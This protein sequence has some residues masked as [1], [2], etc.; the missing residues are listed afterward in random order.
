MSDLHQ[1][2]GRLLPRRE[3]VLAGVSGGVD[4][5]VLM[6]L[7][8]QRG[9]VQV[10]HLNHGLRG[11]SSDA[12]ERLVRKMAEKWGLPCHVKRADVK[13]AAR[14][15]QV[16]I[17]MAAR[18]CRHEF[19]ARLARKLGV[20]KIALA[21]H[22]DDQVELF[23]LRLLRGAGPDGLA[24]MAEV[25]PSFVDPALTIVRPLLGVTKEELRAYAAEH[26]IP[27]REDATNASISILR[28]R[29][30]HI[31]IPL[32]RKDY[33]PGLTETVLRV[34]DLLRAE[35]DF[36]AR[37][38]EHS[39]EP[40]DKL[41]LAL[42]RRRLRRQL[43]A[44]GLDANFD[45]VEHLRLNPEAPM[46]FAP[47]QTIA[48]DPSGAVKI[49][50]D[51]HPGSADA[52][53]ARLELSLQQPGSTTFGNLTLNW[54][55]TAKPGTP[56]RNREYFDADAI[57]PSII[58]RHWQ[59]GDRFQPIGMPAKV[60]LQDLFTNLKIPRARRHQLIL[61]TTTA[62]EI[63][64]VEGLRIGEKFKLKPG[65]ARSLKWCWERHGTC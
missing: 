65:T 23:F 51:A 20:R 58:V 63:F 29:I 40:F 37:E 27:F 54:S 26:K 11:K 42:Q 49:S 7:L 60:K 30:R 16:S 41:P 36:I 62:D 55:I 31:F 14:H 56:G 44:A 52:S 50:R 8:A 18:Q 48:R 47:G 25:S 32:L 24:G 19:Y 28:N 33:Q 53:S 9:N 1:A 5:M 46:T 3:I 4:S 6:H 10:V 59:P 2:V 21:H 64:W 34:M 12:D 61:A 17:E 22:A 45:M 57:G 38:S 13:A 39:R 43:Y 35:S 15:R